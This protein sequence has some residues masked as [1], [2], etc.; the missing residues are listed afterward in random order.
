[1]KPGEKQQQG[2]AWKQSS[3]L[4]NIWGQEIKYT[5]ILCQDSGE[6]KRRVGLKM[7][8]LHSQKQ[9]QKFS[10]SSSIFI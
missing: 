2:S 1:M 5:K 10:Y 4:Q 3:P 7:D 8:E 6:K 9:K